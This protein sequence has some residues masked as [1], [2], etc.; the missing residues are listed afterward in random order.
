VPKPKKNEKKQ[1]FI[2][3][4]IVYLGK[5]NPSMSPEHKAAKC[6][7]IWRQEKGKD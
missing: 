7:G 3:R 4:C 2:S 1:E 6:H 5:E